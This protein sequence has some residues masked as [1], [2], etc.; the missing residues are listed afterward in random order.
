MLNK[1]FSSHTNYSR[2]FVKLQLKPWINSYVRS[3]LSAW[4]SAG[5]TDDRKHASYDL[6]RSI[7]AV[8]RQYKTKLK[9][10][11][12]TTTQTRSF[13]RVNIH[14][15]VGPDG[16]PGCVLSTLTKCVRR[17]TSHSTSTRPRNWWWISEDRAEKTHPSPSTRHLWSG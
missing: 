13:K 12:T 15:A 3:G 17:T 5:N 1:G 4:T 11:S 16:I 2:S 9:N 6:R 8:K 10:N 14:K 7:K